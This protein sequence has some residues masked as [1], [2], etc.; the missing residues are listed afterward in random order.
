MR[1]APA[2][3]DAA[4]HL[5][6]IHHAAL[7]DNFLPA[8][9]RDFLEAVYY[10]AALRSPHGTTLVAWVDERPAG[11]VTVAH[12][13]DHFLGACLARTWFRLPRYAIV[14][15]LRRP[16]FAREALEVLVSVARRTTDP[17]PGEI[18]FIAV[19]ASWRGRGVGQRLVSAALAY[20]AGRGVGF[21]RTKTLAGNLGAIAMYERMGWHVR[22]RF[23]LIG[24]DYV[25]LLSPPIA[26]GRA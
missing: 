2:G 18:V 13:A 4:A 1:V 12:D 15:A 9:G 25:T 17:V 11:F 22:D 14:A 21:C 6:R 16:R 23:R 24:R 3:P 10:P 5:A 26:P 7:P 8:L 20:L 19:D